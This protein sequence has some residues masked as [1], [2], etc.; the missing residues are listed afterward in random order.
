MM[1]L[2]DGTFGKK[3]KKTWM[4]KCLYER[5]ELREILCP[6]HKVDTAAT[7]QALIKYNHACVSVLDFSTP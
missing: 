3:K 1:V 5:T 7:N 2:E 6:I 4:D